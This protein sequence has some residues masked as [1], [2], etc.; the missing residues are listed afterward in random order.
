MKKILI[1]ISI[2]MVLF[3]AVLGIGFY[4]LNNIYIPKNLK[5]MVVDILK[6]TLQKDVNIAQA[7]YFPFRGVLFSQINIINPDGSL[8]L[9]VDT[10]DLG[11]NS[12]PAVKGDEISAKGKL[13]VKGIVFAQD[14][15]RVNGSSTVNVDVQTQGKE[16]VNFTAVLE[17]D[18]FAINGL[19]PVADITQ[20][21][22]KIIC[23]Q[24]S[25]SSEKLQA[26]ISGQTLDININGKYSQADMLLENFSLK[27][28]NT[29]LSAEGKVF[30]F[31]NPQVD[32][33]LNGVIGLADI[34]KII[35]G[36]PLPSISGECVIRAD[37]LGKISDLA[38]LKAFLKADIANGA[39]DKIKFSDFSAEVNLKG[40]VVHLTPLNCDFYQG[41]IQGQ[42]KATII[43]PK[44][45][46]EC[47]IDIANVNFAPLAQ[48]FTSQDLGTGLFNANIGISGSVVDLNTLTGA[49]RVKVVDAGIKPPPR[50]KNIAGSLGV[51]ALE[52]MQI[53]EISATLSISDG[54][55]D[56]Q[57]LLV[58]AKEAT[59]TGKGYVSLEQYIDFELAFKLNPEFAQKIG[60]GSLMQFAS[61]D[62]GVPLAK[63]RIYGTLP[64]K[65]RWDKIEIPVTEIIK[66]KVKSEL[67]NQ[68][69]SFLNQEQS[70][71]DG[72]PEQS[73]VPVNEQIKEGLKS[74]KGLFR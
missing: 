43:D 15:I 42:A 17:L 48:D 50:F 13:L 73:D 22:G 51:S 33:K 71:D 56:T 11:L 65:T 69:K 1:V 2:L 66:N 64:D 19:A 67:E 62:D 4:Y 61:G 8:F 14:K 39:V 23:T 68:V 46:L 34:A 52:G 29:K 47:S 36:I 16:K 30:E 9:S 70:A 72:S 28:V 40:G 35:C 12:L 10:V 49:G 21:R 57:D 18:N 3:I 63:R 55:I 53:N 44:I 74:L 60:G 41:K 58:L 59:I 24:D 7:K 5:P 54:K 32:L 27:Y 20:I 37:A 25:F 31:E 26:L 38:V 45:P 6:K